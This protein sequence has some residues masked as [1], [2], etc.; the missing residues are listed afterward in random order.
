[1]ISFIDHGSVVWFAKTVGLIYLLV[2]A[3][4]ALVYALRPSKKV[5]FDAAAH[6]ILS[7]EERP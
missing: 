4:A 3:V 6:A 1:M 5:E 2:M 7:N